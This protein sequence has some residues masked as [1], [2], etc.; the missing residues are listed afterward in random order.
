M[1]CT[2]S[3]KGTAGRIRFKTG[4]GGF[5]SGVADW[6]GDL[7]ATTIPGGNRNFFYDRVKRNTGEILR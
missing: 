5:L 3:E 6:W 1:H 7:H 2:D 4:I